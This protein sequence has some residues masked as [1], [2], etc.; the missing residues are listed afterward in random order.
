M[1]V[2]LSVEQEAQLSRMAAQ[3]G[4]PVDEFVREVVD[5]Y[6]AEEARFQAAVQAGL[7]AADHGNFVPTSEVWAGVDR[8]LKA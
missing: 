7:D 8:V 6:L 3:A 4:R 2:Q 5:R 1:E